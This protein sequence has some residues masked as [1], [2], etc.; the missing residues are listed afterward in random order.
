MHFPEKMVERCEANSIPIVVITRT[1]S[2]PAKQF[3]GGG[4]CRT[5]LAFEKYVGGS[6]AYSNAYPAGIGLLGRSV[7]TLPSFAQ[8]I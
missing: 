7:W 8:S 3:I 6:R 2:D 5:Y 1:L 4:A